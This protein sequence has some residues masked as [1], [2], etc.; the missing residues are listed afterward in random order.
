MSGLS[1]SCSNPRPA[2]TADDFMAA[3]NARDAP[4]EMSGLYR[5]ARTSH[6]RRS[7]AGR[8]RHSTNGESARAPLPQLRKPAATSPMIRPALSVV[9]PLYNESECV[10]P[11]VNAVHRALADEREWE[12]VLVD[13][14]RS[15]DTARIAARIA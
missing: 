7:G 8:C 11:L 10:A 4:T 14:G 9:V 13:D 2:T 3:A 12:L 15:D 6:A 5:I 1:V